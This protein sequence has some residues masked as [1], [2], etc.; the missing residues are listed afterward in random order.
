MSPDLRKK[1]W[2]AYAVV[3]AT[4][5]LLA[6]GKLGQFLIEGI[7]FARELNGRPYI[8]DFVNVYNGGVLAR[9]ALAEPINIYDPTVQERSA[10]KLVAPVV[11]EIP[12][13][14][15]YPPHFFALM[16]PLSFFSMTGA[17]FVWVGL[18]TLM[19]GLTGW[20]LARDQLEAGFPRAFFWI[21]AFCAYPTWLSYALGQTTFMLIYPL[22]WFW[23]F[24]RENKG[25]LAGLLVGFMSVKLQYSPFLGMIGL[26]LG[27]LR[28]LG[29]S[30]FSTIGLICFAGFVVGRH[31]IIQYPQSLIAGEVG[32][33]VSG[34]SV[35]EM[36]NLRGELNLLMRGDAPEI[37]IIV[38]A[39]GALTIAWF[40]F[41]WT[42]VY[43]RFRQN[44]GKAFEVLAAVSTLLMLM[45]SPH[46]HTQDYMLAIIPYC[47]LW[48]WANANLKD[49]SS[50]RLSAINWMIISYPFVSWILYI[51]KFLFIIGRIQPFFLWNFVL[52]GLCLGEIV[53]R[54]KKQPDHGEQ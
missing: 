43:K 27:K 50:A 6:Y 25:G 26:V 28:F 9:R 45:F 16:L 20:K 23:L 46:T 37:N 48:S 44:D 38:A 49:K 54:M 7:M 18:G 24:L 2:F 4:W 41:A 47:W 40:V 13:Y 31:N 17:W 42:W 10:A 11:A 22:L 15:Q 29:T 19:I 33:A 1:V 8:S 39:G 32:H 3:L 35:F 34:V 21:A 12:F 51:F 5:A 30:I 52:V 36:Q 53:S 14:L